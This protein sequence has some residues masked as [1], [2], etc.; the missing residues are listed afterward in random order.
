MPTAR[1]RRRVV[2][3]SRLGCRRARDGSHV[4]WI[5]RSRS[6]RRPT[7]IAVPTV[8]E[9]AR[10]PRRAERVSSLGTRS[11]AIPSRSTPR[12]ASRPLDRASPCAES[13]P[14]SGS[15]RWRPLQRADLGPSASVSSGHTSPELQALEHMRA[16]K[17]STA[18]RAASTSELV[19]GVEPR[20]LL[21]DRRDDP[22]LLGERRHGSGTA[23]CSRS[24]ACAVRSPSS[25]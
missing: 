14:P 19:G 10:R 24:S 18:R 16:P 15:L 1:P 17:R 2:V 5:A 7:L 25:C 11:A 6:P 22:P 20:E 21:L 8:V 12:R 23:P 13:R 3:G 4:G 9:R